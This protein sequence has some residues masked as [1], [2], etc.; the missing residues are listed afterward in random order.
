MSSSMAFE[1]VFVKI[2]FENNT[3]NYL[4]DILSLPVISIVISSLDYSSRSIA[5]SHIRYGYALEFPDHLKRIDKNQFELIEFM[6]ERPTIRKRKNSKCI[7]NHLLSYQQKISWSLL[8]NTQTLINIGCNYDRYCY[9][10]GRASTL[11]FS[12]DNLSYMKIFSKNNKILHV[13][14]I[15]YRNKYHLY[16]HLIIYFDVSQY[17]KLKSNKQI[18]KVKFSTLENVDDGNTTTDDD[19]D[20]D[21]EVFNRN[22]EPEDNKEIIYDIKTLLC[23]E[24]ICKKIY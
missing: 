15:N 20:D 1:R 14:N 7:E 21:N 4:I 9:I 17:Y 16:N 18:F 11:D 2:I 5:Y 13:S 8:K 23:D 10:D 6:I 12:S 22:S 19:D 3:F 24:S